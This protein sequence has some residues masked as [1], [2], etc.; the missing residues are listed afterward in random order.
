MK[1]YGGLFFENLVK[2]DAYYKLQMELFEEGLIQ[3]LQLRVAHP[4]YTPDLTAAD[5]PRV[6]ATLPKEMKFI[7]HYGA[8]NTGARQRRLPI[9]VD[10]QKLKP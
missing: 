7:V 6:L 10:Y 3:G 4:S 2:K 1:V 8:E 5:L 9:S